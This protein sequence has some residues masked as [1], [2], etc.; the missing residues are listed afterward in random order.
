MWFLFTIVGLYIIS[1][2]IWSV[3]GNINALRYTVVFMFISAIFIP[4]AVAILG[5][6]IPNFSV[7]AR[8]IS[9]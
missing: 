6:F 5:L 9:R 1:P 7:D 2:I 3:K 8:S 4:N